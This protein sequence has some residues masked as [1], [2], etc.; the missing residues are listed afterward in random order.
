MKA[1][2]TVYVVDDDPSCRTALT[3]MLTAAGLTVESY[4]SG[5][6]L[7]AHFAAD[8]A[9]ELSGCVL[10]DL[11][12]PALDGLQLQQSCTEA[13]VELPFVFLTGQGDIP[14]AVAAMRHGAVDFLDKSV[15]Q[16]T[17]LT[18][19]ERALE[20]DAHARADRVRRRQL[21]RRFA[22]LTARERE[23]LRHL[24]HGKMNTQIAT[25]L[26]IHVRT[27][28]LHRQGISIKLGVRTVAELTT[29][30]H[31]VGLV[32]EGPEQPALPIVTLL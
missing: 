24:V 13:G 3:R 11:H 2:G 17:L 6:E 1:L 32:F 27:V 10:A 23:V 18:A 20:R 28:N 25:T 8:R 5:T 7:L 12:M 14:S 29:L 4:P 31:Q 30:A 21:E 15:P 9:V 19:L 16:R 26:G 22:A